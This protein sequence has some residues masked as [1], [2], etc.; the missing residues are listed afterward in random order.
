[1]S[2]KSFFAAIAS[3]IW[4]G[5]LYLW[6]II[7]RTIDKYVVTDGELRAASFGYYAF[8]ALFPLVLLFVSASTM[9]VGVQEKR[10]VTDQVIHFLNEY[11]PVAAAH[12]DVITSTIVVIT[13]GTGVKSG[14]IALLALVWSSLRFFQALVYGVNRA[15]GTREYAWWHLP[16]VNLGMMILLASTLL[17]G[18]VAPV[19][20]RGIQAF[21]V[22][23][24]VGE[25]VEL[26][27]PLRT[28]QLLLPWLVLFSGLVM[29]YKYAPY[30][31]TSF[32]EVW[33]AALTVTVLF[34]L[35]NKAFVFYTATF[36][37]RFT[38]LYGTLGNVV[39][40]LLWIYLSGTLIILGGCLCAA[41]FEIRTEAKPKL[42]ED[43]AA[44]I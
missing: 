13:S 16:L 9:V 44:G 34:Q 11:I 26:E 4:R 12:H 3:G 20:I 6:R 5:T 27:S 23:Y 19:I 24:G 40:V 7:Y 36:G 18:V 32:R 42:E 30:R 28:T 10:A 15:W 22:T 33:V 21:L 35:L 43:P 29:F 17:L 39:A 31:K 41:Q 14:L 2:L 1:M 37:G 25:Y 38:E 8:F